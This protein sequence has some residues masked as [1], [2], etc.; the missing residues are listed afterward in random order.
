MR[1][2]LP[3]HSFINHVLSTGL[4]HKPFS[5]Q[6]FLSSVIYIYIYI[7]RFNLQQKWKNPWV[8][9]TIQCEASNQQLFL[10]LQPSQA[11]KPRMDRNENEM[12][13]IDCNVWTCGMC[14]LQTQMSKTTQPWKLEDKQILHVFSGCMIYLYLQF[15]VPIFSPNVQNQATVP[16]RNPILRELFPVMWH[17]LVV[18]TPRVESMP[19]IPECLDMW[20]GV[21][22]SFSII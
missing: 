22:N 17:N 11:L 14:K 6:L 20:R 8:P 7:S 1:Q 12:M 5:H 9:M 3:I 2:C 21:G 4:N 18:P 15:I 10:V 19:W 16:W 13:N